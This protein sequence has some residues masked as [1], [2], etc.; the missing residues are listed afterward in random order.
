MEIGK[1]GGDRER[2]M[3]EI[4]E[5]A[6]EMGK[7]NRERS[8]GDRGKR[9][10]DRERRERAME[11]GKERA[12]EIGKEVYRLGKSMEMEILIVRR[13]MEIGKEEYN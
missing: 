7:R 10:G 12:M 8:D 4:R 5:G 2:A 1:E 3:V 11:I 13:A 9:D 6:M